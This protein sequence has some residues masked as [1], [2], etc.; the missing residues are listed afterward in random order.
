[1]NLP[2][3]KR[4]P[5]RPAEWLIVGLGNPGAEY[6]NTRHNVGYRVVDLLA[7]ANRIDNRHAHLR[8]LVGYGRI[9]ETPVLLAKPITYMNLSGESIAPLSRFLSI[10]PDRILIVTDDMDLPVGK[11]RLRTGGSAGGHNGLKS[12]IQ[13]LKTEDFPRIKIGVGRPA[14][15]TIDHVLGKFQRA[16]L[17]PIA[18]ALERAAAAVQVVLAEGMEPAMSRFNAR[19]PAPKKPP[20][21]R[22]PASA[23]TAAEP[24]VTAGGAAEPNV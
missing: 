6:H 22:P 20:A 13:H 23:E 16:E 19:E 10:A 12:L 8:S 11:I 24:G 14:G 15:G 18:E 5:D 2:F 4:Q 21:T 9:G 7:Q 17:E 3:L 1:M